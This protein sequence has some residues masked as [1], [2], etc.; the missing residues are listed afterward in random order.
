[1]LTQ[2]KINKFYSDFDS[3]KLRFPNKAM[4]EATGMSKSQVSGYLT[5]K[6]KPT[7]QFVK[8]FYE[9]IFPLHK[10][11]QKVSREIPPQDAAAE[12]VNEPKVK[13]NNES[14]DLHTLIKTMEDFARANVIREE[15]EKILA[16]AHLVQTRML[17]AKKTEIISSD[18]SKANQATIIQ[19]INTLLQNQKMWE[20]YFAKKEAAGDPQR[21][22]QV[23]AMMGKIHA[24]N[25]PTT[26]KKGTPKQ[27]N[28]HKR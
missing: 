24:D 12:I 25:I 16:E 15:K 27:G 18:N 19:G 4:K 21:E 14:P 17:E 5:K 9:Q 10:S 20:D 22:E 28:L 8:V 11:S 23:R 13:H 6:M 3:L 26:E 1:M 2:E 7:E